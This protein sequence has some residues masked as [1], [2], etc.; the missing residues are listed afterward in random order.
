[1]Q[2]VV[3]KEACDYPLPFPKAVAKRNE[4]VLI[5]DGSHSSCIF[6]VVSGFANICNCPREMGYLL[7]CL[8]GEGDSRSSH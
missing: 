1:M 8:D 6:H 3:T 7:F 5:C 4:E 2:M